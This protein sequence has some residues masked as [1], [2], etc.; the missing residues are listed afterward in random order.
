MVKV[1]FIVSEIQKKKSLQGLSKKIIEIE[2]NNYS[3]K[4]KIDIASLNERDA[5]I[6]VQDVRML[7]RKLTGRFVQD[8]G[9]HIS[10][11]ERKDFYNELRAKIDNLDINSILDLGCGINPLF[12]ADKTKKY[13]AYDIDESSISQ[14]SKFLNENK[15]EGFAKVSDMREE[16]NFHK[17]DLCI[18][19]KFLDLIDK[20]GHKNAESLIKSINAKYFL[21]SF[22]TKTLSNKPMRHPQRGWIERLLTRLSFSYEFFSSKNEI[23]YLASKKN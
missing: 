1:D 18:M 11:E 12:L 14:V 23:F 16:R 10:V 7:L 17:V 2:V 5:K 15:I 21:I 19:F 13:Y 6:I 3:N 8:K 4:N 9:E 22:P 20:N